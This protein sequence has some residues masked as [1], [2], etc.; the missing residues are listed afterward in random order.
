VDLRPLEG[1]D[2]LRTHLVKNPYAVPAMS[3][4]WRA[5]LQQASWSIE[6]SQ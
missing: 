6:E 3:E 2:M 5:M 4:Q 1:T